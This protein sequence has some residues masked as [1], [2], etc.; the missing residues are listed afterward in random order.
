[1]QISPPY[2]H[3]TLFLFLLLLLLPFVAATSEG[4]F[5]YEYEKLN[6]I[7]R[8]NTWWSKRIEKNAPADKAFDK[9]T[10]SACQDPMAAISCYISLCGN[11]LLTCLENSCDK[12]E[13]CRSE[14]VMCA[15]N[16][17]NNKYGSSSHQIRPPY[18]S[19]FI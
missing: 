8:R 15:R 4:G 6:R 3:S 14:H 1:M 5:G 2:L 17:L 18:A 19:N 11:K 7:H 16:C 12:L 10:H 9:A 13:A